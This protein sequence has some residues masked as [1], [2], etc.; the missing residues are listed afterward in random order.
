MLLAS[1][2]ITARRELTGQREIKSSGSRLTHAFSKRPVFFFVQKQFQ[3]FTDALRYVR[4][5][6][7]KM[8]RILRPNFMDL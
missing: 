2:T 3:L 4:R 1:V 5:C 6:Q 8:K 7:E